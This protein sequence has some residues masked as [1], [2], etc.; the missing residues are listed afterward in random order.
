MHVT[1]I[2]SQ[3]VYFKSYLQ[4]APPYPSLTL[5]FHHNFERAQRQHYPVHSAKPYETQSRCHPFNWVM[6]SVRQNIQWLGTQTW[7]N[8]FM[9]LQWILKALRIHFVQSKA[10]K[11]KTRTSFN[12]SESISNLWTSA[13]MKQ[14]CE[15]QNFWEKEV[16][17]I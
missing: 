15:A 12:S 4:V 5:A 14:L 7:W 8:D 13:V 1:E 10:Q 9:A 11:H 6:K 16:I 3:G 17:V 2:Q